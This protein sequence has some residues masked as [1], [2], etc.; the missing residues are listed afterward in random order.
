MSRQIYTKDNIEKWNR[1]LLNA[2]WY[3]FMIL[4]LVEC[5]NLLVTTDP[6]MTFIQDYI[7]FPSV[8]LLLLLGMTECGYRRYPRSPDLIMISGILFTSISI[9]VHAY[10]DSILLFY[11]L[12]VLVATFYFEKKYL[13]KVSVMNV[14]SFVTLFVL[15]DKL[16]I[17]LNITEVISTAAMIGLGA[18][19][20]AT[21][22]I[23]RGEGILLSI[24]FDALSGLYN[25]K[26]FHDE[27]DKWIE[28]SR[29][30]KVPLVLAVLDIDNF[31]KINDTY[32]HQAGD[33]VIRTISSVMLAESGDVDVVARY[34]GEEFAI[35]FVDRS[36]E[37]ALAISERIRL[38]ISEMRHQALKN[39]VCTVS[40]GMSTRSESMTKEEWFDQADQKLYEA[41]RA[42]KNRI[43]VLLE[44]T[45]MA[46]N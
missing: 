35:L 12:P 26:A 43:C 16:Q 18:P 38:R 46:R 4:T 5:F 30:R 17:K 42:G 1:K 6:V 29:V 2:Y 37:E 36:M 31:K 9:Y 45:T 28:S 21:K 14:V 20:V 40:I 34:G 25:H 23:D 10:V 33:E 39:S 22:I 15:S 11:M 32:G 24:R 41:K 27:M 13:W 3:S 7:V 44:G 19:Y 8:L